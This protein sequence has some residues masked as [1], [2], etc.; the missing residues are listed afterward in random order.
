[1]I[2]ALPQRLTRLPLG[3]SLASHS[4]MI[5]L[6][7]ER[8]T[9]SWIMYELARVLRMKQ[10]SLQG[11]AKAPTGIAG[12]DE[13]TLGGLPKGRARGVGCGRSAALP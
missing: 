5:L 4:Q 9:S 1:M 6:N 8:R 12:L 11:L 10:R 7:V 2:L 13:I 3:K